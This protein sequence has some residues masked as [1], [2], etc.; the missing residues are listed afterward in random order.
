L[1]PISARSFSQARR[2]GFVSVFEGIKA[3]KEQ[4][5]DNIREALGNITKGTHAETQD[6]FYYPGGEAMARPYE[7]AFQ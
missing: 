6:I 1:E 3:L 2:T 4:G 7:G 5:H